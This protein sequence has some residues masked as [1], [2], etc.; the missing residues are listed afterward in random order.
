L[1]HK[2]YSPI[3]ISQ[4]RVKTVITVFFVVL[5]CTCIDPYSPNLNAY[6]SL[7]VVEGLITNEKVPYEI[8]LSRTVAGVDSYPERVSDAIVSISVGSGNKTNLNYFGGGIYKTD[9]TV[10]T[11]VVGKTYILNIVTHD[12]K[13]YKSDPCVMLPVP[14]IDSLYYEK[15]VGFTNNQ[16]ESNEGISIYLDSKKG[17]EI[18]MNLRWEY[19]ET[20]KFALPNPKRYNYINESLITLISNVKTFCWKQQKSSEILTHSIAAGQTN[21]IK[22]EPICFIASALSAR[23]SIQYSI[24][25]KQYSI[26]KKESEFWANLKKVNEGGSDIFGSQPF[27][28]ISN[29]SNIHNP[30][31]P[32][33]GYFQVSAVTQK[34]KYITFKESIVKLGLPLYHYPPSCALIESSP[35][36]YAS[37]FGPKPTFDELYQM[38]TANHYY[39]F[40]EP[41][42]DPQTWKLSKLVFSAVSCSDCDLSETIN[43][44]DFWID[45]N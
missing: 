32:V 7:L 41:I 45:L 4:I 10:F 42:Y 5:L 29:I 30:D 44:P 24:L 31:E 27:P 20:W 18:N 6:E 15:D 39:N 14:E 11:G 3:Q 8:K 9:S 13:E 23:L 36:D 17:N 37:Q 21:I 34:R 16:T 25:V 2:K 12:G 28:V 22:K 40:I 19:E 26:S 38:W 43:K 1:K 35:A 33:L